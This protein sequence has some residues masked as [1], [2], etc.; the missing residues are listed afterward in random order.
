MKVIGL[1]VGRHSVKAYTDDK[2]AMFPAIIGTYRPLKLE[3]QRTPDDMEVEHIGKRYYVGNI[4]NESRDG[5]RNFMAT[6]AIDD[7]RILGLVAISRLAAHEEPVHLVIGHP[8][9]NHVPDEKERMKRLML[10]ATRY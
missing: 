9:T 10:G 4:A 2:C 3:Y 6:K 5:R 1:D 7:T 8:I